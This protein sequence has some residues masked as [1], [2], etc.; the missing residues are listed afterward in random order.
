MQTHNIPRPSASER[1]LAE[2]APTRNILSILALWGPLKALR[3][4]GLLAT[5]ARAGARMYDSSY[6]YL[7]IADV[8]TTSTTGWRKISHAA[9]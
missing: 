1:V 5:P 4:E 9:L 6:L 8:I 7:S 3:E 2:G